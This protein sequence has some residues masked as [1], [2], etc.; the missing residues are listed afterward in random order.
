M[1][2]DLPEMSA[3]QS[4]LL[5]AVTRDSNVF[6]SCSKNQLSVSNILDS[7][8][9]AF[10]SNHKSWYDPSILPVSSGEMG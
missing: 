7:S 1:L 5:I 8:G 6:T 4:S 2:V 3:F 9:C 10:M